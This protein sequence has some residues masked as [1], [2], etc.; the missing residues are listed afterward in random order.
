MAYALKTKQT[1]ADV[2]AFLEAV[3][4]P[5]RRA[6]ANPLPEV[7][8]VTSAVLPSSSA[9]SCSLGD[10]RFRSAERRCDITALLTRDQPRARAG[11]WLVEESVPSCG[12]TEAGR[13]R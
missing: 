11:C 1:T 12:S 8:P 3:P 5:S 13:N 2:D 6:D 7:P 9:M 4:D 10:V